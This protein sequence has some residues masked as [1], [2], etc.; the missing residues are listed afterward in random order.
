MASHR[1]LLDALAELAQSPTG[2][3]EWEKIRA[4]SIQCIQLLAMDEASRA[5]LADH[6]GIMMALTQANYGDT[7]EGVAVQ[8]AI[9]TLVSAM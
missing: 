7:E 8:Q 5:M 9:K 6:E 4:A 1:G 3:A 2:G